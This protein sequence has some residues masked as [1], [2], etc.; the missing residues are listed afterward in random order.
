MV[1]NTGCRIYKFSG[2]HLSPIISRISDALGMA[3]VPNSESCHHY[4]CYSTSQN[5]TKPHYKSKTIIRKHVSHISYS[6]GKSPSANLPFSCLRTLAPSFL[7][8]MNRIEELRPSSQIVR[9]QDIISTSS[10]RGWGPLPEHQVVT[11][12]RYLPCD[13]NDLITGDTSFL[14]FAASNLNFNDGLPTREDLENNWLARIVA[15][16]DFLTRDDQ[17]YYEDQVCPLLS[18]L[19]SALTSLRRCTQESLTNFSNDAKDRKRIQ[20]ALRHK[21]RRNLRRISSG[22]GSSPNTSVPTHW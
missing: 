21:T 11:G 6:S 5:Q 20:N 22:P 8:A 15:Y 2:M 12:I 3:S 9:Y 16:S 10:P 17:A 13:V 1:A 19:H 14:K 7:A 4:V 18:C